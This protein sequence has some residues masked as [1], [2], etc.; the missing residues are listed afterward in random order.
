MCVVKVCAITGGIEN[1]TN[2]KTGT[3]SALKPLTCNIR[4]C[5]TIVLFP[6]SPAP[7]SKKKTQ[8]SSV[9]CCTVLLKSPWLIALMIIQLKPVDDVLEVT[10]CWIHGSPSISLWKIRRSER[11]TSLIGT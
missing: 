5:L 2:Q 7:V 8:A 4:I 3:Y 9:F 10:A 11:A 1:E 6:D